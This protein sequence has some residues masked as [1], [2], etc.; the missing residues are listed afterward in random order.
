MNL[1]KRIGCLHVHHSNID[2]IEKAT[3]LYDMELIHFVDPGLMNR[4]TNDEGF[5]LE[6]AND[7]VRQQIEWIAKCQVDAILITCTHYIALLDDRDLSVSVPIIKIDEPFFE[8]I[9]EVQQPQ[10]ILFSNPET[11]DGTMK[12]LNQYAKNHKKTI[13]D[14]E[15]RVLENTFEFFMKGLQE[16]Y[17]QAITS[18]LNHA[19]SA[20]NHVISVAQLSMVNGAKRAEQQTGRSIINPLDS[21]VSYLV[22]R[23]K[24]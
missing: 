13:G 22:H 1:K 19:I 11:V 6:N 23:W 7:K 5:S 3:T 12:R 14:I 20:E 16:E 17:D 15:V 24:G 4:I 2:Y 21:L 10:T 8:A 9:C 18:A